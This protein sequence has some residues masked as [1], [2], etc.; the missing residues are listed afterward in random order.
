MKMAVYYNKKTNTIVETNL[1]EE[2]MIENEYYP[3]YLIKLKLEIKDN[4][5]KNFWLLESNGQEIITNYSTDNI[6]NNS[7]EYIRIASKNKV[8][9]KEE[10]MAYFDYVKNIIKRSGYD[11]IADDVKVGG[12]LIKPIPYIFKRELSQCEGKNIPFSETI[13]YI[14]YDNCFKN[15]NSINEED[16]H[17]E[18]KCEASVCKTYS[19]WSKAD[20]PSKIE[21]KEAKMG[22][23]YTFV[24][25]VYILCNFKDNKEKFWEKYNNEGPHDFGIL[26]V[27]SKSEK[28]VNPFVKEFRICDIK[29]I[30]DDL[31]D[32]NNID[33]TM[34]VLK[35][36][37]NYT[38]MIFDEN[39]VL[40]DTLIEKTY[41]E[42]FKKSTSLYDEVYE[43]LL[44]KFKKR[45]DLFQ[46]KID[47]SENEKINY[48]KNLEELLKRMD[49]LSGDS[50]FAKIKE[51]FFREIG[52]TAQSNFLEFQK[53]LEKAIN[54]I[55]SKRQETVKL[56]NTINES[57][58]KKQDEIETRTKEIISSTNTTLIDA[59]KRLEIFK[60]QVN[61]EFRRI[62]SR[63]SD[64]IQEITKLVVREVIKLNPVSEINI[65]L[66]DDDIKR[67]VRGI[68]HNS[69]KK[70]L[71]LIHLNSPVF[72]VGPAG[73]G[74][75]VM[76]KQ[77]AKVLDLDFY[78]I[79]DAREKYDLL[80]FVDANGKYQETQFFK[81]FTKGGL[82]MIDELDNADPSVLLLLNSALG[83]G[84]DFYMTFPDGNHYSAHPDFHLVA[85]A[86]TF[87]TGS[88][89]TYCGR[90]QLDGASLNRFVAVPVDYDTTIE[91]TLV[92]NQDIL[93]LYWE[94]RRIIR[95]NEINYVVSTR[96]ILNADKYIS[97]KVFDL[98]D[99]FSWTLA[100]S[101][102]EFDLAVIIS[103]IK[104][105]D[106]YSNAFIDF[107][108]RNY[109][110][111][112][113]KTK[114]RTRN[115]NG[116]DEE[117]YN[118]NYY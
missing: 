77:A 30:P 85:A 45:D 32:L 6:N 59:R 58:T 64:M 60:E 105:S 24:S 51:E 98:D 111:E 76:L 106:R 83:T 39:G 79:N 38:Q 116:Y 26:T 34:E 67:K 117:E 48:R 95:E 21:K 12:T 114:Q 50:R 11:N 61:D 69:F 13:K 74:K 20:I 80:G 75:N 70:V 52:I 103:N 109:K 107:V 102:T 19:F 118:Y 63:K 25:N 99:I 96:N 29:K 72:L 15:V 101:M 93:P 10:V 9:K 104:T 27:V 28:Y 36:V 82:L 54:D 100:G 16:M 65:N 37:K 41:G 33:A 4:S 7:S 1:P 108:K 78:Y 73:C 86:N 35:K 8:L 62:E 43:K 110:I 23:F 94:V 14:S 5:R 17:V 55:N 92:N 22:W 53:I 115:R 56:G 18:L 112:T 47:K 3:L 90:N 87:G 88:N 71:Q 2:K 31:I 49:I 44:Q 84:D 113:A 89:Q 40:L 68:Y 97:A 46:R 66:G 42:V 91:K 57:L 81:A